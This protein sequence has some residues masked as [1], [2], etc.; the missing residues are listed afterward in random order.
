MLICDDYLVFFERKDFVHHL[1]ASDL[2]VNVQ[3]YKCVHITID[4]IYFYCFNHLPSTM[5]TSVVNA[6]RKIYLSKKIKRTFLFEI[7]VSED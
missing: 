4:E 1:G 2:S 7:A 5:G 6:R 3:F